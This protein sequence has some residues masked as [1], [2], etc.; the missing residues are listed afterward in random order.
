[1]TPR[2]SVVIPCHNEQDALAPFWQTLAQTLG[3]LNG[4]EHEVIFVNDGSTDHTQVLLE[5]LADTD[6]RIRVIEFS[7]NFGKEAATTAGLHEATGN[8]VLTLDADLQH[9]PE[10]IPQF[11]DA[12]RAGADIVVGVR[13]NNASD[14][15]IKKIGSGLYYRLMGFLS[16]TVVT[17]R[18]TDFRLLDRT[19]VDEFK[20]LTEHNRMT[21]GLIDWLGFKRTHVRFTAPER[22]HGEAS[23]ST[24]KLIKL[25]AESFIAH[26]LAPLK[27][28]GYLGMFITLLAAALGFVMITDRYFGVWGFAFSGPAILATFI[29]F[30]VGIVLI[31][32]GLL[33][34]YIGTIYRET[35]NRPLYVIRRRHAASS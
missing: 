19:V 30:L 29:L 17:P 26:S 9:P 23:Y 21:R 4:L 20:R 22:M 32:L 10:L 12:W 33:S 28:A 24:R 15:L 5:T 3:S 27:L 2:L 13:T 35:Q 34:F 1:M 14:S 31:A 25:A 16:E 11:I 6:A 8:V 7:R 18:A